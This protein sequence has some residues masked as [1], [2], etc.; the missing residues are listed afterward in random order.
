V[1][2]IEKTVEMGG[3]LVRLGLGREVLRFVVEDYGKMM[4]V[5]K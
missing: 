2:E 1:K 3:V 5:S 4:K